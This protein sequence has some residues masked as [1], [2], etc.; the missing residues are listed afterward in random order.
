MRLPV[1]GIHRLT[2]SRT[3]AL[4]AVL[5]FASA[6]SA[7][8]WNRRSGARPTAAPSPSTARRSAASRAGSP[9]GPSAGGDVLPTER[10]LMPQV[11][12][13]SNR[14]FQHQAAQHQYVS[15]VE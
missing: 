7:L 5:V 2:R 11:R 15:F 3:R 1:P 9:D 14:Y 10:K 6:L 13:A 8:V 12:Q 4:L